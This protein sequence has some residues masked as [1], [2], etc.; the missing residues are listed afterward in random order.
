MGG[1]KLV[2]SPDL[3]KKAVQLTKIDFMFVIG[4]QTG[5][6]PLLTKR[7]LEENLK[8]LHLNQTVVKHLSPNL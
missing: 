2:P 1:N 7:F 4:I 6:H 3:K 5:A 8:F